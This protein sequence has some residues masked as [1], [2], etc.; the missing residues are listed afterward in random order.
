MFAKVTTTITSLVDLDTMK[1]QHSV[2]VECSDGL[3]GDMVRAVAI[4]AVKSTLAAL[5]EV[6]S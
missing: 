2:D 6:D 4:G 1:P 5:D 3:P